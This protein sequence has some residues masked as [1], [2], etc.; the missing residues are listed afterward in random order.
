MVGLEALPLL[1]REAVVRLL[2]PADALRTLPQVSEGTLAALQ[3]LRLP[4]G[5]VRARTT[6]A[7]MLQAHAL[8]RA[9]DDA[10]VEVWHLTAQGR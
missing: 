7:A 2:P 3:E 5:R 8:R 1:P 10:P 6:E 4:I 9:W